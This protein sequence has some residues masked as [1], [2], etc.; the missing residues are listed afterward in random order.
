MRAPTL[1]VTST[2]VSG[3]LLGAAAPVAAENAFNWG[4]FY[5]IGRAHV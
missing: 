2:L 3:L 1:I 4:G 5:E